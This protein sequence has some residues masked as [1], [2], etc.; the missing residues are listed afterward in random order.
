MFRVRRPAR[1][2]KRKADF[3]RRR[4]RERGGALPRGTPESSSDTTNRNHCH[5]FNSAVFPRSPYTSQR[6]IGPTFPAI[7]A[8]VR[9]V[10]R[11]VEP[12]RDT[13]SGFEAFLSRRERTCPAREPPVPRGQLPGS[14]QSLPLG[15]GRR[16]V[17]AFRDQ[18]SPKRPHPQT[19]PNLGTGPSKCPRSDV[20]LKRS[21]TEE[22]LRRTNPEPL[23]PTAAEL[24]AQTPR[25]A[26][27]S[28]H[29]SAHLVTLPTR[30]RGRGRER[31]R[32]PARPRLCPRGPGRCGHSLPPA[33]TSTSLLLASPPLPLQSIK[34]IIIK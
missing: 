33:C 19:A 22:S 31:P 1:A 8:G 16:H 18:F 6:A 32:R 4:D 34:K 3:R 23:R 17:R 9:P 15:R 12:S 24:K 13:V 2:R 29:R 10:T 7:L 30:P 25:S 21:L 26:G 28:C 14:G 5:S 11:L 20:Y 27:R